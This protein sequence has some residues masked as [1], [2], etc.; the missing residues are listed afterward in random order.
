MKLQQLILVT[1]QTLW[2][3]GT[4]HCPLLAP[5]HG[6]TYSQLL[7]QD[8]EDINQ[9]HEVGSFLPHDSF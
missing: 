4:T 7:V 6:V 1:P 2:K 5:L 9:Y 3:A 8:R